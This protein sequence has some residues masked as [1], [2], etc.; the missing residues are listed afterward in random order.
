MYKNVH[1]RTLYSR[2]KLETAQI[3]INNRTGEQI[4]IYSYNEMLYTNE[5]EQTT[6][7]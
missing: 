6:V 7:T 1:S 4:K 2:K 5:N 3:S